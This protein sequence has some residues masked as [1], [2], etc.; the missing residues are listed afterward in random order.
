LK[1]G[2]H[3]IFGDTTLAFAWWKPRESSGRL[4]GNRAEILTGISGIQV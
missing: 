1:G 4:S 2:G 3:T